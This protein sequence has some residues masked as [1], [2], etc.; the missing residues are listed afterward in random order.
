M[1]KTLLFLTVAAFT[2]FSC[3]AGK[4]DPV[5]TMKKYITALSKYDFAAARKLVT[6]RYLGNISIFEEDASLLN[7]D[8]KKEEIERMS[9]VKVSYE[10]TSKTDST[11]VVTLTMDIQP[12]P[13]PTVIKYHLKMKDNDWLIDSHVQE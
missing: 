8:E 6:S 12:M 3:T 10:L 5:A 9:K 13:K 1:K 7:E 4:I 2:M 11:A